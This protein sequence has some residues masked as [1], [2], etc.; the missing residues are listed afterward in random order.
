MVDFE[1]EGQGS[2][3]EE[4]SDD[5][6]DDSRGVE[7]INIERADQLVFKATTSDKSWPFLK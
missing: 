6:H 4:E 1:G 5:L 3:K 2:D 7:L